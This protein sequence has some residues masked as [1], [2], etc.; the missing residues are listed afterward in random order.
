[1]KKALFVSV[2]AIVMIG[3]L[4]GYNI[5]L[6]YN[7]FVE[8]ELSKINPVIYQ[9]IDEELN[10]RTRITKKPDK[11]GTQHSY[12]KMYEPGEVVPVPTKGE[13]ITD[14]DSFDVKKLKTDGFVNSQSELITLIL[15]DSNESKGRSIKLAVLDTIFV[16]N[17]KENYEHS[18]LLLDKRK[19]IV[20]I[21]GRKDIPSTWFFSKDYAV[22]LSHPK[23]VR[24]AINIPPSIFIWNSIGTLMLSLLFVLVAAICIGYQLEDIKRKGEL[25]KNRELSVNSIIHDL[26]AP[27]N[28]VITL[29]GV[30][31]LKVDESSILAL[32]QQTSDKAKQ[33]V[34]DIES[35]LIAASGGN[36][37]IILAPKEIN[38]LEV[39]EH[40]KSDI[41]IIY[42]KKE[43]QINIDDLTHG[44]ATAKADRMYMLNVMRNLIENAIKYADNGV[45]VNVTV[46]REA[47]RNVIVS[48]SDN[49]WGIASK[50]QKLIFRQFYRVPHENATK[51]HGIGLALVK[52]VV[53]AHGGKVTVKSEQGEGSIFTFNIPVK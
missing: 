24:V 37:R 29:L 52:Y 16:N 31:K 20:S 1:M 18:I 17:L 38:I 34:S 39:A 2:L 3:C 53:E 21:Y 5:Y 51:G 12:L 10:L 9:S 35:I 22:G 27:I 26:K 15:Q 48:V 30:I 47:N 33:L 50:D 45:Q 40:A 11:I 44:N 6:Q 8:T 43:H 13:S 4:Q 19:K 7:N 32:I 14:L 42:N 28:S 49:G 23:F 46:S 25:L 41:D 36:K